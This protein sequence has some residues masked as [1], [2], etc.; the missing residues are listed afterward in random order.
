MPSGTRVDC[1][2]RSACSA[3]QSST[4]S[5]GW[6]RKLKRSLTFF[7]S[8]CS[9]SASPCLG[10]RRRLRGRRRWRRCRFSRRLLVPA[11][12]AAWHRS[13]PAPAAPS[14]ALRPERSQVSVAAVS[15][16]TG[17][18]YRVTRLRGRRTRAAGV[19]AS[20][21]P[22]WRR[23]GTG[24]GIRGRRCGRAGPQTGHLI[25]RGLLS[26]GQQR[27]QLTLV[28]VARHAPFRLAAARHGRRPFGHQP[29]MHLVCSAVK[30]ST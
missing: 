14:A 8:A 21:L 26:T 30:F 16:G 4:S 3:S 5:Q 12:A 11:D 15:A 25:P 1:S 23:L 29:R 22:P 6:K 27:P 18:A 28:G 7:G 20:G 9:S 24:A 10:R 19:A 17:C 13:L 2:D